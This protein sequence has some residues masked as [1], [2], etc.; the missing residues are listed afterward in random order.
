VK[1]RSLIFLVLL[2]AFCSRVLAQVVLDESKLVVDDVTLFASAEEK[3]TYYYVPTEFRI[4]KAK[5]GQ[6]GVQMLKFAG[7]NASSESGAI[8]DFVMDIGLS[9]SELGHLQKAL[10]KVKP[11]AKIKGPIPLST[12]LSDHSLFIWAIF[13]DLQGL[14]QLNDTEFALSG[15]V[16]KND[17]SL[18]SG[19]LSNDVEMTCVFS[20]EFRGVVNLEVQVSRDEVL[21]QLFPFCFQKEHPYALE[22]LQKDPGKWAELIGGTSDEFLERGLLQLIDEKVG[23]VRALLDEEEKERLRNEFRQGLNH[24]FLSTDQ[25]IFQLKGNRLGIMNVSETITAEDVHEEAF[26]TDLRQFRKRE[27]FVQFDY[28]LSELVDEGVLKGFEMELVKKYEHPDRM[29]NV[30]KR[31]IKFYKGHFDRKGSNTMKLKYPQEGAPSDLDYFYRLKYR[32]Q[33]G[34]KARE[35]QTDWRLTDFSI[36]NVRSPL[37]L[38]KIEYDIDLDLFQEEGIEYIQIDFYSGESQFLRRVF[39]D[40]EV[41]EDGFNSVSLLFDRENASDLEYFYFLTYYFK[42]GRIRKSD[43]SVRSQDPY[44]F[45]TYSDE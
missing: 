19:L 11:G 28:Y 24:S 12:H 21:E 39:L 31:E 33:D 20:S 1:K 37:E 3:S 27:V 34:A 6:P 2:L 32:F 15:K 43:G 40:L 41:M 14:T 26:N 18:I 16:D 5:D 10:K 25:L 9:K 13:V 23:V 38:K 22:M 8:L 29:N 4:S 45:F 36:I 7:A 17:A 30:Y 35:I 42:D 44:I